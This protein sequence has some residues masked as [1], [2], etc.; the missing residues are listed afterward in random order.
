MRPSPG[1]EESG[2]PRPAPR[3]SC[4]SVPPAHQF[5]AGARWV[6][7]VGVEEGTIAMFATPAEAMKWPRSWRLPWLLDVARGPARM[8][9]GSMA[10][11]HSKRS[12]GDIAI[13][14]AQRSAHHWVFRTDHEAPAAARTAVNSI[15]PRRRVDDLLL[16]VSELVTNSVRHAG[17]G[18][19]RHRRRVPPNIP[20]SLQ[21]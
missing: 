11:G 5:V 17:M 15:L 8:G 2:A 10:R 20:A 6:A 12:N 1:A 16:L 13:P 21:D 4:A 7:V 3:C 18:A 9:S 19:R 14:G